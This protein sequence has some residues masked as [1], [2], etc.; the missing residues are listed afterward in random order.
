M[1]KRLKNAV[2]QVSGTILM[3]V[4]ALAVGAVLVA[5][6][7]NSPAEAYLTML[8]GAFGSPQKIS[9]VFVKLIPILLMA[10]GTS[11]AFRAKL[12]NIGASGQFI[13]GSIAA[14]AVALYVD[15]PLVIRTPLSFVAALVGRRTVG[16]HCRTAEGEINANEVITTL[17]LNYIATY[18]LLYLVNGPMQDPSSD[19]SQSALVPGGDE[20]DPP[21]RHVP[22]AQRHLPAG[23]C[24]DHHDLLLAHVSWLSN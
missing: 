23:D 19:L 22:S 15:V 8:N 12:W 21:F 10:F 14:T 9:E 1:N 7:G 2:G 6:S 16:R 4:V 5:I 13:M 3:L 20:A 24:H 18:F 11:I 17:M